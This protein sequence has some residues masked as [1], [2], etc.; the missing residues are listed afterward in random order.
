MP[1]APDPFE[2]LI[3]LPRQ[4]PEDDVVAVD[5]GEDAVVVGLFDDEDGSPGWAGGGV[6]VRLVGVGVVG[7]VV[8]VGSVE[9]TAAADV[10][11]GVECAHLCER[12]GAGEREKCVGVL[13]AKM[14]CCFFFG[15]LDAE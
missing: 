5:V 6:E 14:E 3:V 11:F 1:I 13:G 8:R 15:G 7:A 12:F 9:F 2:P 4:G 10:C